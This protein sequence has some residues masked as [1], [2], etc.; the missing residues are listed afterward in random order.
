LFFHLILTDDCNLCC[1]Y[2]R[3]R[4]FS[5]RSGEVG[6]RV[7][8]DEELP[9][10]LSLDLRDLYSFLAK[11]PDA[12]L[13]FYGG[14]PL[15]RSDLILRIM[16]EA[17]GIRFML[18]TNGLKL[19]EL[20]EWALQKFETILVSL[21][22]TPSQTDRHRGSGTYSRVMENVD[23]IMETGFSGEL[24]AR[25]TICED[26]DIHDAVTYLSDNPDHGFSSIHWQ[27]DADFS[28]DIEMRDLGCWL[29]NRYNPGILRLIRR[30]VELI[31]EEGRV[32]R[33]YPFLDPMEDLLKG[34]KTLLRCGS[35]H[36]NYTIMTDGSIGPCPV[37]VGM[38]DYYS[39]HICTS[40]PLR[41]P[42][43]AIQGECSSC[44]IYSFCGGRC[45]YSHIVRPWPE[46][47]R[48]QICNSV[49]NL[50]SGLS[51]ALP[52]VKRLIREDRVRVSDFA[53]TKFNGCEIIP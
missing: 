50:H 33:W 27:L 21:D 40:D 1:T 24:I 45:L 44:D 32:P 46:E 47:W 4:I 10:E 42:R 49:R 11:D 52:E 17:P 36:S 3:G 9:P 15:M 41:L 37:M 35:G 26:T 48:R 2:C 19:G 20:P 6:A 23:K 31:G 28:G 43:I 51:R 30:W 29:E 8:I 18:Q 38:K 7:E 12:C 14:E 25:M 39:G 13:T 5:C 22:G 34:E 53:H 16:Q